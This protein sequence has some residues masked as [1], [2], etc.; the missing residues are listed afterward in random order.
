M[1]QLTLGDS[2]F[3]TSPERDALTALRSKYLETGLKLR[4]QFIARYASFK[5]ADELFQSLPSDIEA[6]V[7]QT[8][9]MAA[10]DISAHRV[11]H[12]SQDS[13]RLDLAGRAE[14]VR[15]GLDRVQNRY[16]EI[17]GKA[18]EL[19][20]QRTEARENRARVAGGGFGVEG[21]AQGIAI[22]AA[23]N[24]AIGI[25]HG[26]ANLTAKAGSLIGD[27]RKKKALLEDPSTKAD[28]ADFLCRIVLQGYKL[29]ADI[30]NKDTGVSVF[31]SVSD[32]AQRKAAA[33]TENVTS[34]R[35]PPG[36]IKAALIQAL[37]LDPF[38]DKIWNAWIDKFGDEDG[39]V[40]RSAVGVGVK[41]TGAYKRKLIEQRRSSLPWATPEE[42]RASGQT[43]QMR[44]SELGLAFSEDM[45]RI[46]ERAVELD[47]IRR[48]FNDILHPTVEKANEARRDHE[49][50]LIEQ[51][52]EA[53]RNKKA[54]EFRKQRTV[55]GIEYETYEA[56]RAAIA[57]KN[58]S[59]FIMF[60]IILA[61]VV[62]LI[63]I[64]NMDL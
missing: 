55:D 49:R 36:D 3:V 45:R 63:A 41:S 26:L 14:E 62:A 7:D 34:G 39:S 50:M 24:I 4:R 43:L 19:D 32:E 13:I 40:E 15:S 44:A 31:D 60:A 28:L 35:V 30:V 23:A 29:V 17:I 5:S 52:A 22:A 2:S 61:T 38:S 11:Y 42:C 59:C 53:E 64:G 18:A 33:L 27:A 8:V 46:E 12:V 1:A 56:A 54:E 25:T 9:S 6:V 51:A 58:R 16:F 57:K 21:A 48:T 10:D 37:E 20:A 47:R